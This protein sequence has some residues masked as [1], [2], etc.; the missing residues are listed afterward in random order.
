MRYFLIIKTLLSFTLVFSIGACRDLTDAQS[1]TNG[2]INP[3]DVKTA[4]AAYGMAATAQ[5]TWQT[6][7]GRYIVI[8][9][10][11]TDELQ[12]NNRG[13]PETLL[14]AGREL[15]ID[16]RASFQ[17]QQAGTVYGELHDVRTQVAQAIGALKKYA[18]DSSAALRGALYA[19]AAYAEVM[20][21]DLYC[22]GVPLSTVNYDG[23][24]TYKPSSTTEEVYRHAIALF[25]SALTLAADSL[26]IVQFA[27]VGKGR[28]LLAL[29]EFEAAREAVDAV[30]NNFQHVERIYVCATYST[31]LCSS[32]TPQAILDFNTVS[33][34]NNE[35][36]QSII[37]W[38][39]PRTAAVSTG[40]N[41]LNGYPIYFPRKYVR[42]GVSEV[43]IASGVEAALI[44]AEAA[45]Q[46]D[47][48]D[49]WLT[50]LNTLRSQSPVTDT[51]A[52]IAD[53][54]AD[55]RADTLF[56]E[57]AQWLFLTGHR[58]GDLRR[59]LRQDPTRFPHDLYPT[60]AYPGGIVQYGN[61]V[62]L[63]IPLTEYRNPL[64]RGCIDRRP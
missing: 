10:L 44:R 7:I 5:R 32:G 54:G 41:T 3:N 42:N 25:D 4:A 21:A 15:L 1:L 19:Y 35:G 30:N 39:N 28:A 56:A 8:S 60:G 26:P 48:I 36:G 59:W 64:Y 61:E 53:P 40:S 23:D 62:N 2:V 51:M 24:Y 58:Q 33:V 22:S 27:S 45:L 20:L 57:R 46:A 17:E 34:S 12:S 6:A 31:V 14:S 37:R 43:V 49:E 50:I 47:Q 9:G 52:P 13:G 18:P 29:G 16:V 38:D 55:Y 63:E 11:L